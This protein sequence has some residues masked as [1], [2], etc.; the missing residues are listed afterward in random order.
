MITITGEAQ[1][2]KA[3]REYFLRVG[4]TVLQAIGDDPTTETVNN[5]STPAKPDRLSG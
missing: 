2:V 4:G 1:A 3:C 5:L